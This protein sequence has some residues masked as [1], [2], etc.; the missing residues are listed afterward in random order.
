MST[1]EK[2]IIFQVKDLNLAAYLKMKGH[3]VREVIKE[4]QHCIFCFVDDMPKREEDCNKYYN[5]DGGYMTYAAIWRNMK[6]M[7][8]NV[9]DNRN[10]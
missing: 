6:K 1:D 9:L 10:K 5:D 2:T 4:G 8:H 7:I 3:V